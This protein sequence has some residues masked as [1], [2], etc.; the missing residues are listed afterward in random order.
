MTDPY[1]TGIAARDGDTMTY[2]TCT[3][4]TCPDQCDGHNHAH[5]VKV[6]RADGRVVYEHDP[7]DIPNG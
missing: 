4:A 5:L 3:D 6:E 1:D 7:T 2:A